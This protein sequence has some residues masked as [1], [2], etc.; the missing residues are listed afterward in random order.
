MMNS[1]VSVEQQIVPMQIHLPT[2]AIGGK[3]VGVGL[4]PYVQMLESDPQ[5]IAASR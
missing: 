2:N 1:S 4:L 5:D 3:Y